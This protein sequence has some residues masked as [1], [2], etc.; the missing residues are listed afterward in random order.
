MLP[1]ALKS[2]TYIGDNYMEEFLN[3]IRNIVFEIKSVEE[4]KAQLNDKLLK[5]GE[6]LEKK[7]T[8]INKLNNNGQQNNITLEQV[9]SNIINLNEMLNKFDGYNEHKREKKKW[10]IFQT[11][12]VLGLCSILMTPLIFTNI[13]VYIEALSFLT[14]LIGTTN[15]VHYYNDIRLR[16]ELVKSTNRDQLINDIAKKEKLK[17]DK[18]KFSYESKAL[19]DFGSA[20]KFN[21]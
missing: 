19:A 15:V 9:S 20:F 4:E 1:R 16:K 11:V 10:R 14:M 18:N 12:I 17:K 2:Y 8:S 5:I 21:K 7:E 13:I 3:K 6:Q